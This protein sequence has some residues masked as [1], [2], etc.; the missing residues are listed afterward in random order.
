M[1]T[2]HFTFSTGLAFSG[3][4][5][6]HQ[7]ALRCLP[8][9]DAVQTVLDALVQAGTVDNA[10]LDP[11]PCA[12]VLRYGDSAIEY[13]LRLWTAPEDYWD[14]YFDVLENC[15]RA[16]DDA[17]VEMTYPHMNIHTVS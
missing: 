16:F 15:K 14:V 13:T 5:T 3:P 12:M 6:G 2:L 8:M 7:L 9:Q 11:A 1:R 17:G 10:L 4:V